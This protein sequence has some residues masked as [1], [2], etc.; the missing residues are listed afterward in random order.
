MIWLYSLGQD[1][2]HSTGSPAGLQLLGGADLPNDHFILPWAM[3]TGSGPPELSLDRL[4]DID[5]AS[6]LSGFGVD[7]DLTAVPVEG[8]Q[9]RIEERKAADQVRQGAA[10]PTVTATD[11]ADAFD[12]VMESQSRKNFR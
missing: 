8:Q 1:I 4:H 9:I 5:V 7:I 6:Q 12:A 11:D 3:G 10:A 2:V